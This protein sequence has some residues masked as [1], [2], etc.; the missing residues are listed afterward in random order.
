MY[1]TGARITGII[2]VPERLAVFI[3]ALLVL[4]LPTGVTTAI[5]ICYTIIN[6]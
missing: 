4:A 3:N 6:I 2:R 5:V 1:L